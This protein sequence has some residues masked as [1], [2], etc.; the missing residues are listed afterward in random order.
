[1]LL[2]L[3]DLTHAGN[4]EKKKDEVDFRLEPLASI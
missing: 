4:G 3:V 1:M 2:A